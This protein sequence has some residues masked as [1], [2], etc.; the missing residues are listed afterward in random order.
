[1]RDLPPDLSRLGR[2]LTAAIDRFQRRQRLRR[3][4]LH[5]AATVGS[6]G[7]LLFVAMTPAVLEP[8]NDAIEATSRTLGFAT[9]GDQS[10]IRL[11]CDRVH[12]GP[13]TPAC[14]DGAVEIMA[15]WRPERLTD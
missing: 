6:A 12:G 13:G 8:A 15:P 9:A 5:R 11:V 3:Q 4:L 1:M 2:D 7:A 10:S 14:D